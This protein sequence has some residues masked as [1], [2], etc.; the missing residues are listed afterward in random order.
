MNE[1]LALLVSKI[2]QL[3]VRKNK[4]YHFSQLKDVSIVVARVLVFPLVILGFILLSFVLLRNILFM[5]LRFTFI[6][7][8]GL[9]SCVLS[10]AQAQH[11]F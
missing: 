3:G 6:K 8:L 9:G 7:G 10:V 4:E 1:V 2:Y 11:V 5:G